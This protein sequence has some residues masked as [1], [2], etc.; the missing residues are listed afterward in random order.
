MK[1]LL[2]ILLFFSVAGFATAKDIKNNSAQLKDNESTVIKNYDTPFNYLN[3]NSKNAKFQ[4]LPKTDPVIVMRNNNLQHLFA[5]T[6]SISYDPSSNLVLI[7]MITF[8]FDGQGVFQGTD[9]WNLRTTDY[10]KSW[11]SLFVYKDQDN[12]LA[13]MRPSVI[14]TN[15]TKSANIEDVNSLNYGVNFYNRTDVSKPF[16]LNINGG[17]FTFYSKDFGGSVT[18]KYISPELGGNSNE[19]QVW[20]QLYL[21]AH[22]ASNK[23]YGWGKL[24]PR[25]TTIKPGYYG[26]FGFDFNSQSVVSNDPDAWWAKNFGKPAGAGDNTP[27][28]YMGPMYVGNDE[29]DNLYT[30]L[31]NYFSDDDG[32]RYVAFSKS[33]DD[34]A[35][36]TSLNRIPK[37]AYADFASS[38]GSKYDSWSVIGQASYHRKALFVRGEDDFSY[39]TNLVIG[40]STDTT[41]LDRSFIV[42]VRYKK[43][44]WSIKQVQELNSYSGPTT[45]INYAIQGDTTKHVE[46]RAGYAGYLGNNIEISKTADGK[47]LVI[48]WL[49]ELPKYLHFPPSDVYV[50]QRD[51]LSGKIVKNKIQIDSLAVSDIFAKVLN[52]ETD[53]WGKTINLTNDDKGQYF[54]HVP[55]YIKDTD[56]AIMLT[57]ETD[58]KTY[59]NRG[60]QP[61]V[62]NYISFWPFLFFNEFNLNDPSLDVEAPNKLDFNV[63][64]NNAYPNPA[65]NTNNVEISFNMEKPS[66][67]SMNLYDNIGNKVA[68]I[69]NNH[70]AVEGN[71]A[72]NFNISNLNTGTY[73]YQLSVN[74]HTFTKKL[75]I[76]K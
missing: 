54:F 12:L 17:I 51:P 45:F 58:T 61:I 68:T 24:E 25:D 11:D 59:A 36:W 14:T 6:T 49:D 13:P 70:Y 19:P 75:M 40:N 64:L 60:P 47:N 27:D 28:Q 8:F 32:N 10:G 31:N 20:S 53:T 4:G 22:N 66:K 69:L 34:G 42:D 16:G 57:Y 65:I 55:E 3:R 15:P 74:G 9:M 72:I 46:M 26:Y 56:H 38:F 29:N 2:T 50:D 35:N 1:K 21:S 63:S 76:V 67:I 44:I 48:Y 41:T 5:P 23:I 71:N 73:F 18:Q 39:Y 7:P 43:G 33:T 37:T 52:I 62:E 30:V